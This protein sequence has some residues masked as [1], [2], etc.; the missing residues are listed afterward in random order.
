MPSVFVSLDPSGK[1]PA[2]HCEDMPFFVHSYGRNKVCNK[3][4]IRP[5]EANYPFNLGQFCEYMI[6]SFG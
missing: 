2:V 3:I 6:I 4:N 1:L 5:L